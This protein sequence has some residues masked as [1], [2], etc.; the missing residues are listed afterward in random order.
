MYIKNHTHTFTRTRM[1][2]SSLPFLFSS[3]SFNLCLLRWLSS[4]PGCFMKM[5]R[6][7]TYALIIST[8]LVFTTAGEPCVKEACV[9]GTADKKQFHL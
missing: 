6:N 7:A 1:H 2:I 8:D 4:S 3:V 5:V 9:Y